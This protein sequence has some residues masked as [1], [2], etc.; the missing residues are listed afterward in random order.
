[1]KRKSLL[2]GVIL[3]VLFA[4]VAVVYAAPA[5][6]DALNG[7][8]AVKAQTD[9]MTFSQY[10][11]F[12]TCKPIEVLPRTVE[13][14]L[15]I[16][17]SVRGTFFSSYEHDGINC[18]SFEIT[19]K[20]SPRIFAAAGG[21]VVYNHNLDNTVDVR[22]KG[23][24][25]VAFVLGDSE[26][27]V[28]IDGTKA[29]AMA[30]YPLTSAFTA[31]TFRVGGDYRTGSTYNQ[32]PFKGKIKSLSVFSTARTAEQVAADKTGAVKGN[33]E[34]LLIS[35]DFTDEKNYYTVNEYDPAFGV[36]MAATRVRDLSASGNDLLS[37]K[38]AV[39]AP[40]K[41]LKFS[42]TKVLDETA[43]PAKLVRTLEA[44]VNI[45][46]AQTD[47]AGV[48]YGN[49][50]DA[51]T[52]YL[53]FEVYSN[54]VPRICYMDK[55]NARNQIVLVFSGVDLRD[56]RVFYHV[57][58]TLDTANKEAKLPPTPISLPSLSPPFRLTICV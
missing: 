57:A 42:K 28:Y 44:V 40:A 13:A 58:F 45:P 37:G 2:F 54:G 10:D 3:S 31:S 26:T 30:A 22:N 16:D 9:G 18:V 53:S 14:V 43:K 39:N 27:T 51:D 25:H 35:Y 1:M 50:K 41:G 38:S 24:V 49:H 33:V 56:D 21:A 32:Y 11:T 12:D 15:S 34:G 23:F 19:A 48:I 5:K 7:E 4:F 20:G 52:S 17:Q 8:A 36:S 29:G 47:R 6:A 46:K 55:E